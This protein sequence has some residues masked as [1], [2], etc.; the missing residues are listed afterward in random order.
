MDRFPNKQKAIDLAIWQN[1]N[2]R[3]DD[4]YGAVLSSKG[5][6]MVVQTDHPSF[7]SSEFETLP[8]GYTNMDYKHIRQ[9]RMEDDPLSH[10][11]DIAGLF[12]TT[13]GEV[14]QFILSAKTPL[15]K[16]IRYELACRGYDKDFL[17]V[18]FDKAEAIWLT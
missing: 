14:L 18:G 2:H 3:Y 17:W 8:E 10:W 6:Y 15:E 4:N 9:I 5:D 13:H 16:F 1:H 7:N 12:S 11:E